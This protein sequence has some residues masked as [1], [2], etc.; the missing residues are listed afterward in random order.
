MIKEESSERRYKEE[1]KRFKI[2]FAVYNGISGVIPQHL[3]CNGRDLY[4]GQI[5]SLFNIII[6]IIIII[7]T[8]LLRLKRF[9]FRSA[10]SLRF[11]P[12]QPILKVCQQAT[13]GTCK[14]SIP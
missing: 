6:A 13:Q 5:D 7:I 4:A 1:A 10:T 9:C 8:A 12:V 11:P 14:L 2:F 3:V